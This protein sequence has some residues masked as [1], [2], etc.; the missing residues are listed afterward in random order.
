MANSTLLLLN[1]QSASDSFLPPCCTPP[2]TLILFPMTAETAPDK[3]D[4]GWEGGELK[5]G[6]GGGTEYN[7]PNSFVNYLR[8]VPVK[9]VIMDGQMK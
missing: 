1:L 2:Q 6:R 3:E 9:N 7:F 8:Y 4:R 5:S